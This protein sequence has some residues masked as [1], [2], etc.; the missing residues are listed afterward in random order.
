MVLSLCNRG[1]ELVWLLGDAAVGRGGGP[2]RGVPRASRL[3]AGAGPLPG[4][5]ASGYSTTRLSP[6][7]LF[8]TLPSPLP[9]NPRSG[10]RD[11]H[12]TPRIQ[13]PTT[14][15][16]PAALLRRGIPGTVRSGSVAANICFRRIP[17]PQ[18]RHPQISP[19]TAFIRLKTA[20]NA[21]GIPIPQKN[22]PPA[23]KNILPSPKKSPCFCL[24]L[25]AN[26][27]LLPLYVLCKFLNCYRKH[28]LRTL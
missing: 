25:F 7:P 28:I 17:E 18:I 21:P 2:G 5:G 23:H 22:F 16:P 27:G 1:G 13:M 15:R 4:A 12:R 3:G 26:P 8:G 11:L 20:K 6:D 19:K 24:H 14:R 10:T 9:A